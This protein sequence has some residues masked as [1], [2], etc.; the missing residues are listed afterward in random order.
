MKKIKPSLIGFLQAFGVIAYCVLIALLFNFLGKAALQPPGILGFAAILVILVFSAA[1]T[2]S[3]VFGYPA[4]LFFSKGKIKEPLLI[5][6]FTMLYCLIILAVIAIAYLA[7]GLVNKNKQPACTMAAKLCPDGSYVGR[8]GPNCEFAPCPGETAEWLAIKRAIYNCEVETV[9]Q[10]HSLEVFARL[11]NGGTL[12]AVEPS[13]D[14][15]VD[16]A[17]EAEEKC[18]EIPIMTE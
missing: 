14:D 18:G 1:V 13:I 10:Y 7:I 17:R 11:K 9:G 2:G 8:I 4:Y 16:V 15:I 6:A 3:I 5:L 12:D